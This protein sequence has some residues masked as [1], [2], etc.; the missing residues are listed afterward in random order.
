MIYALSDKSLQR[1]AGV[2]PDLQRCVRRAIELTSVDFGVICGLR[3][4]E[5][6]Q[7][8]VLRGASDILQSR[9]LTGH[10]VDLQAYLDGHASDQWELYAEIADAMRHAGLALHIPLRWGGCWDFS[11]TSLDGDLNEA[12]KAYAARQR[13]AGN[14]KPLMDGYHF[15]LPRAQYPT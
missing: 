1:M 11:L 9:H 4:A 6:Q 12:S 8:I 10:A 15:E 2:H 5:Q 13:Q 3:T 14:P 7:A